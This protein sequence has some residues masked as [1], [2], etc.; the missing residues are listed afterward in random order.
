[1][2]EF[3]VVVAGGGPAGATVA[4]LVAMD[5]HRVLLLEK[6][7]FPRYRL[8]ETLPPA[9]VHG[10]CRMLG[11]TGELAASDFTVSRGGAFRW[12]TDPEPWTY[13]FADSPRLTAQTSFGYQVQR[14]RFDE[15]LLRNARRRGVEVR[16]GCTATGVTEG[17]GRASGLRYTG[18]DGAGRAV[19][20]RF[21]VDATGGEGPLDAGVGAVRPHPGLPR[22]TAVSGYFGRCPE[23]A[24]YEGNLIAAFGGGWFWYTQIIGGLCSVGAVLP[25]GSAVPAEGDREAFFAALIAECPVVARLLAEASRVRAGGYGRLRVTEVSSYERTS[26]WRPG[27]ILAGDAACAVDPVLSSGVHLATYGAVL[28]ARSVGGVLAGGVD[29][30][31][32]LT[33]FETRYRREYAAVTGVLA[34][35]HGTDAP[36]D[37]YFQRA[38][39]VTNSEHAAA[40]SFVDLIAGVSSGADSPLFDHKE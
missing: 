25:P 4:T 22:G 1:M 17:D 29:E 35:F 37:S 14:A 21:V 39:E 33:E 24:P 15:M 30:K 5:G 27:V 16:E 8:G 19:R 18:P 40:E 6:E 12:G 11:L 26:F 32:A 9:T 7:V 23:P 13:S 34:S 38:R 20:A 10:V 36:A 3:D 2:E 28:A 31:T